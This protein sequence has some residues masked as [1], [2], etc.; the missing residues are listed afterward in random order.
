MPGDLRVPWQLLQ[1]L[2]MSDWVYVDGEKM[3][4]E[5]RSE[6]LYYISLI[7]LYHPR[8]SCLVTNDFDGMGVVEAFLQPLLEMLRALLGVL[9]SGSQ[10]ALQVVEL[11]ASANARIR[12]RWEARDL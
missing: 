6:D 8:A 2:A 4:E 12:K 1:L 7:L 5:V 9:L 11:C 3:I 10:P